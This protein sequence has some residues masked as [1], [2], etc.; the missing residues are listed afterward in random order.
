MDAQ[1]TRSTRE[2]LAMPSDD[3]FQLERSWVDLVPESKRTPGTCHMSI[4]SN[5]SL[6]SGER[7]P[8]TGAFILGFAFS[9]FFDG[10]LLHQILQWHH[11]LSLAHGASFRDV[12]MQILADGLFHMASYFLAGIGMLLV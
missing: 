10:I 3:R 11:L 7:R 8:T 2:V 12:R 5:R 9:A 1:G 6:G 4:Y